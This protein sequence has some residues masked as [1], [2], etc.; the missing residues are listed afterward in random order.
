MSA[1]IFFP[2]SIGLPVKVVNKATGE[3]LSEPLSMFS[4]LNQAA[5]EHG[6]GRIDI[7]ENR[8]VGLKSR[9]IYETPGGTVLHVAHLDLEAL[10]MDREIRR[11]KQMLALRMSEMVYCGFWFS[12]E[13]NYVRRCVEDS[14]HCVNGTV[15]VSLFKGQGK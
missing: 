9:G 8:F 5:G 4:Y 13:F 1:Y 12:P 3:V 6:V 2:I 7:V 15:R 11:I 14:Q 10:T